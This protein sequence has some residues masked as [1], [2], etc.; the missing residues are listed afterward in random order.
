MI[1]TGLADVDV[2]IAIH[3]YEIVNNIDANK[4]ILF[5]IIFF[6]KKLKKGLNTKA[7]VYVT[8]I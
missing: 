5:E 1:P 8:A 4:H 2:I 3:N 7:L 6:D